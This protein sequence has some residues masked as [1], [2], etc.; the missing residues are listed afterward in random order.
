MIRGIILDLEGTL[1]N[2]ENAHFSAFCQAIHEI[3]GVTITTEEVVARVPNAIGGGDENIAN[4][5]AVYYGDSTRQDGLLQLKEV[6]FQTIV[7]ETIIEA[8][9]GVLQAI[10]EFRKRGFLVA[11]GSNTPRKPAIDYIRR[12]GITK[13]M[14]PDRLVVVADDVGGRKKPDPAVFEEARR[15]MMFPP[16][17]IL[18]FGDAPVDVTAAHRL[19][20]ICIAMP[21]HT[22]R[23]SI[24]AL[25]VV[26]PFKVFWKW[27]GVDWQPLLDEVEG[28]LRSSQ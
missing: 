26:K 4:H 20:S 6:F 27:E 24:E 14:V 12:I 8:R 2:L 19:G 10:G 16:Q 23:S 1:V 5:L 13:D 15:R 7:G 25:E 21:V 3:F 28:H 18:V 11:I 17:E 22:S 9:P